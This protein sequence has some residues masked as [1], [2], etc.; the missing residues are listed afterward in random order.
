LSKA[1]GFALAIGY[2]WWVGQRVT[3]IGLH[4]R[5]LGQALAL[6]AGITAPE[7]LVTLRSG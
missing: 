6:G 2:T 1:L 3:A 5:N 7:K 4:T